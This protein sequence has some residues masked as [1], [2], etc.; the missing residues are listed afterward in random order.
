MDRSESGPALTRRQW[1]G[2]GAALAAGFALPSAAET[3]PARARLSLNE[4]PYGPSPLA[5]RAIREALADACRYPG[6]DVRALEEQI[7]ACEG[8]AAGQ[9]I[10]G[11]I[12]DQLGLHLALAG[13][14]GGEFIYSEPGYTALVDA[15]AP[16][17]GVAVGVPLDADL[18]NDLPAIAAH[19]NAN[20]RAIYLVN[21]HNPSG[22][23]SDPAAFKRFLH[24]AAQRSTVIVDEAYLEFEPDFGQQSAVELTRA[25]DNVIVFR[26]FAKLY[27]LAGLSI[28]YAVA[29]PAIAAELKRKG[30]GEPHGL[31]RLAIAAAAASLRDARYVRETR[32]RVIAERERWHAFLD[33]RRLR[34]ADS[35]GNF[36]FFETGHPH[37]QFAAALH[38]DGI[39]IARAFTPLDGWARISIGLPDE[40]QRAR[41]AVARLLR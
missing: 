16:G 38:A 13:G 8:V 41:E 14:P 6:D 29:P 22:T 15:V 33:A 37:A 2:F 32:A 27:G 23:V 25:G 40:N 19:I 10:V 36:V 30:L 5:L 20:T 12:L 11:E 31:N 17:G 4:N 24:E 21:P 26:T 39:E 1:L 9:I 28:G 18:R 3:P 7:A 35:R 34:R